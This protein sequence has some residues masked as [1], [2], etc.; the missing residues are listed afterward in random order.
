MRLPLAFALSLIALPAV[1]GPAADAVRFFY[2]P[3][4]NVSDPALRDRFVDPA[5]AIF[6]KDD[7]LSNGGTA[8]GCIDFALQYD[9]Q[10]LDDAE[11]ATTLKL[12]EKV[13][14]DSARVTA[15]F[16]LF[17]GEDDSKRSIV[18]SLKQVGGAWKIADI[19]SGSG[20]WKLSDFEC[21]EP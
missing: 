17:P 21:D 15:N 5:L 11:V 13:K 8:I 4:A 2:T 12:T 16:R 18:W 19:A 9:A 10:D 7:K 14:G 1:A 6:E 20:D 3:Q